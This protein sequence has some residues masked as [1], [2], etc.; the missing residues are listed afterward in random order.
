MIAFPFPL[1]AFAEDHP[2]VVDKNWLDIWLVLEPAIEDAT[3]EKGAN[4][5]EAAPDE[6]TNFEEEVR[7]WLGIRLV[8]EP[9]IEGIRGVVVWLGSGTE[10][11]V[12]SGDIRAEGG[13]L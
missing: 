8:L 4:F 5:R 11:G 1:N 13:F 6:D 10:S 7:G 9:A 3:S 2:V 12:E